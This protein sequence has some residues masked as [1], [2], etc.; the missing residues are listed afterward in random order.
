MTIWALPI[1]RQR[2]HAGEPK[3]ILLPDEGHKAITTSRDA[4]CTPVT[5]VE[6]IK[7]F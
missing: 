5:A 4:E 2:A 7:A 6:E 1:S 3:F